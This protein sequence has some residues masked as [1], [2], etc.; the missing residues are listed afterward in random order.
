MRSPMP[1]IHAR[2]T[3]KLTIIRRVR[4]GRVFDRS[5]IVLTLG[6]RAIFFRSD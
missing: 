3:A 2:V 6:P 4:G 1:T 5:D